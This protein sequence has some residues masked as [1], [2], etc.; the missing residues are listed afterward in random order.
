MGRKLTKQLKVN[1]IMKYSKETLKQINRIQRNKMLGY[2]IY[3]TVSKDTKNSYTTS[4][5]SRIKYLLGLFF[6]KG[7]FREH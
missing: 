2:H 6:I 7:V 1:Y 4:K 5:R 3:Y